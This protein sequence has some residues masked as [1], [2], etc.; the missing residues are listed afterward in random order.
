MRTVGFGIRW[1][2]DWREAF[3]AQ[4]ETLCEFS[5]AMR[6]TLQS[7][8]NSS[9]RGRHSS[10]PLFRLI[11]PR[12]SQLSRQSPCLNGSSAGAAFP[13]EALGIIRPDRV[14]SEPPQRLLLGS[15]S[16][17]MDFSSIL[18]SYASL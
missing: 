17:E 13:C 11:L 9:L 4:S 3:S 1:T 14:T 6:P 2:P 16:A 18:S 12:V 15:R 5:P 10:G 7:R 8:A